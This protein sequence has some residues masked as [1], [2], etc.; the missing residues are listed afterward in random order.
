MS[1]AKPIDNKTGTNMAPSTAEVRQAETS[2]PTPPR[3][4]LRTELCKAFEAS[5]KR[6]EAAYRYLGR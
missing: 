4:R 2:V 5:W 6:N 1:I 3:R